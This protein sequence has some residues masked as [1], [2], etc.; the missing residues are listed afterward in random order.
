M[1]NLIKSNTDDTPYKAAINPLSLK[2]KDTWIETFEKDSMKP[3]IHQ[4]CIRIDEKTNLQ[5][6]VSDFS[7]FQKQGFLPTLILYYKDTSLRLCNDLL[8]SCSSIF[9]NEMPLTSDIEIIIAYSDP[10]DKTNVSRL[11]QN[12]EKY[13]R[14]KLKPIRMI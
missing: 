7:D 3:E 1:E 6:L 4:I 10:S 8:L 11:L 14:I 12:S 13:N 5:N 2:T 9:T